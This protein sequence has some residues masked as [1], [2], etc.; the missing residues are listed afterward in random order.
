MRVDDICC[1]RYGGVWHE[2]EMIRTADDNIGS[3]YHIKATFCSDKDAC[4]QSK[5]M[6][7]IFGFALTVYGTPF[8]ALRTGRLKISD[9][10]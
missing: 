2:L 4:M 3:P 6:H 7:E 9:I 5:G 8:D 1:T 10:R